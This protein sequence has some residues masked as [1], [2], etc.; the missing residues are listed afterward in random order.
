MKNI[1]WLVPMLFLFS[2]SQ[3]KVV[4]TDLYLYFD[5]TEGQN[6]EHLMQQDVDKYLQLMGIT[7]HS[8]NYGTVKMYPLH[9]VS[10]SVNQTVKIK[11][12]KSQLEGNRYVR[13]KEVDQFKA[14]LNAKLANL[15]DSFQETPLKN[16]HI[17]SPVCKGF[18]KMQNSDADQK[19]VII[20]SDMLENS[21]IANL[22]RSSV[23]FQKLQ[24][25]LD[26]TCDCGDLMDIQL[27]VVHPVNKKHDQLIRQSAGLWQQYFT[28]K[29]LDGDNFHFDTSIDI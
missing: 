25:A 26:K 15:N 8:R 18:K 27:Y 29:G 19:I 28:A 14:K 1:V 10:A 12:G 5:Y 13:K 11:E 9:D 23:N 2:C 17:F 7:E 21:E 20:Y 24:T 22:H 3:E 16:S 4:H 6:Y